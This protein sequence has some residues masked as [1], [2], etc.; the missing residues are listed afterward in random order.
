VASLSSSPDCRTEGLPALLVSPRLSLDSVRERYTL[1]SLSL[2]SGRFLFL[3]RS[4]SRT[5]DYF[6]QPAL[7]LSSL[8]LTHAASLFVGAL[9]MSGTPDIDRQC[10]A[11][12]AT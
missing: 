2:C 1:C 7:L 4:G 9:L 6:E 11:Q 12:P 5:K 10:D 8:F 3:S